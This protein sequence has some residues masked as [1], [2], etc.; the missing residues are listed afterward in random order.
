MEY[1]L[2]HIFNI[3]LPIVFARNIY[4]SLGASDAVVVETAPLNS[5]EACGS[6][7]QRLPHDCHTTA[8]RLPLVIST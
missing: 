6:A 8:T 2:E 7:P 1:R 4:I 3:S 5:N